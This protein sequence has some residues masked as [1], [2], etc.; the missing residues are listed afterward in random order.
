[1][2]GYITNIFGSTAAPEQPSGQ[3]SD[4]KSSDSEIVVVDA[5]HTVESLIGDVKS[6]VAVDQ[7]EPVVA[8]DQTEPVVAVDQTEP[9]KPVESIHEPVKPV[10]SKLEIKSDDPP[11]ETRNWRRVHEVNLE[12]PVKFLNG[13]MIHFGFEWK[14]GLNVDKLA[15]NDRETCG[16]GGL[17]FCNMKNAPEWVR[18]KQLV[19]DVTLPDDA[20]IV[21]MY[22]KFK[23]DKVII[24]NVRPIDDLSIWGNEEFALSVLNSRDLSV[25]E[26]VTCK[27]QKYLSELALM[28][29]RTLALMDEQPEALCL[30]VIERHGSDCLKHIKPEFQTEAVCH[31]AFNRG[32]A[33]ALRYMAKFDKKQVLSYLGRY[34]EKEILEKFTFSPEFTADMIDEYLIDNNFSLDVCEKIIEASGLTPNTKDYNMRLLKATNGTAIGDLVQDEE[35]CIYALK[36]NPGVIHDITNPTK[37]MFK[38]AIESGVYRNLEKMSDEIRQELQSSID[39]QIQKGLIEDE[40]TD[41]LTSQVVEFLFRNPF[42]KYLIEECDVIVFGGIIRWCVCY[43]IDNEKLPSI[44]ETYEYL[45]NS[46]IDLRTSPDRYKLQSIYDWVIRHG[47]IM[48]FAGYS[49]NH[50][51]AEKHPFINLDLFE[52]GVY[53]IWIP[54]KMI[55]WVRYDLVVQKLGYS[56]IEYDYSINTTTLRRIRGKYRLTVLNLK[57]LTRKILAPLKHVNERSLFKKLHRAAKFWKQGFRPNTEAKKDFLKMFKR[58]ETLAQ[59]KSGV[60]PEEIRRRLTSSITDDFVITPRDLDISKELQIVVR[61]SD[62]LESDS[63]YCPTPKTEPSVKEMPDIE[64]IKRHIA[65]KEQEQKELEELVAKKNEEWK[66]SKKANKKATEEKTTIEQSA[67]GEKYYHTIED[68]GKY[69][70]T[71]QRGYAIKSTMQNAPLDLG[72]NMRTVPVSTHKYEPLTYDIMM[73]ACKEL[74]EF[75]KH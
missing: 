72:H 21:V 68:F 34:M 4:Q 15:F 40:K 39:L 48:E 71:E 7:T 56:E 28:R 57:D 5:V 13:N 52:D 6:D 70:F 31:A 42:L 32:G 43:L 27:S 66:A 58:A 63:K 50:K 47:G 55:G 11:I 2:F 3:S 64:L 36:I 45:K 25:L 59:M 8:V 51:G 37:E 20:K 35:L 41:K 24:S 9:V 49:Y 74:Y 67:S 53:N 30:E 54:S 65:K 60:N 46:D 69:I 29:P 61:C 14:E 75:C 17:Y 19:A 44:T 23:A 33:N 16:P 62:D 18:D 10:E 22:D 12:N 1:M 26:R 73:E 38:I